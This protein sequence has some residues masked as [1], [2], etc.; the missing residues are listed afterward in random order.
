[1]AMGKDTPVHCSGQLSTLVHSLEPS[2]C[3]CLEIL[4]QSLFNSISSTNP[5][6]FI[7]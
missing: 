6:Y 7:N 5:N 2:L 4:S 3:E 1:M